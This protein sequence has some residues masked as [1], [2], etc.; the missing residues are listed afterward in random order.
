MAS[1]HKSLRSGTAN[2]RPTT[3]IAEGQIALNTNATSPGLY[4]KD[5][6]GA[7]IIKIGPVHVGTTAPNVAP[8]GS[9]G[10]STGEAWLDTSLTPNGWKVWTGAAWVNATPAGSETVQGLLE[11]AT[12]A[13]T[14]AGSDT[15]RAVTPAGL[16]S[17]VSD[18]TSTTSSTTIAS[19]TAVK[20]AYDL[21]NAA[22]PKA[23]GTVTGNLEIGNTGSLT[24]EGATAD[25]F[26]TTLA[27]VNPTADRTITLPNVTGTVVTTGDTGSVTST[28]ILDGTI[29]NADVNASAAIAGTKISPDFGS[30]NIATTGVFSHALGTAGSPTITFTGNTN[31]GIYSPAADTLAFTEGGTEA[32]RIDSSGRLLVGTSTARS[33]FFNST[34]TAL[35]QIEGFPDLALTRTAND[36]FSSN[37]IFAKTRSSGNTIVQNNDILGLLSFQGS[38]GSEFVEGAFIQ[39]QVDGT[40]GANDMPGRLVFSTTADG[41]AS[42]TERMRIDSSGRVGIGTTSP[43]TNYRLTVSGGGIAINTSAGTS[44]VLTLN[45][46]GIGAAQISAGPSNSLVFKTYDGGSS[47]VERMRLDSLGVLSIGSG[48]NAVAMGNGAI[49]FGGGSFVSGAG[50]NALKWN[51]ATGTVTW[52]SSSRL[53]KENIEDL[54]Y[55][56]AELKLL[57]PRKYF[58][59]DDEKTEIGFIADEVADI[60]PELVSTAPKSLFSKNPD[61]DQLVPA[62]VAYEKMTSL[63][64]AALQEAI[65][66]IETLEARLTAAGIE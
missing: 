18:S 38:D 22:L 23:G 2:K 46:S 27:V 30:Q 1:T 53:V 10:N 33:N 40:P 7:A 13:E 20:A 54:P 42:A 55:G 24:F 59:I 63:L 44:A 37:F 39:A 52:D 14:Q 34:N 5:S 66:K 21:A 8:A 41:A 12:N 43:D 56:I 11:L 51:S 29:L 64:T 32:M 47:F 15:A 60:I 36:Q 6:T 3:S 28:M 19:S 26:E 35:V 25:A 58:R 48:G 45:E 50:T 9:S 4:F 31:T 16:Q 49:V 62:S 65:A 17:K 61:D 57:K